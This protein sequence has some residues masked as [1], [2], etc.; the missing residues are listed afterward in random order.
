MNEVVRDCSE[1]RSCRKCDL[2]RILFLTAHVPG[3]YI[4]HRLHSPEPWHTQINNVSHVPTHAG[5][6]TYAT[7]LG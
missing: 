3:D 7:S 5:S 1:D 6:H 4:H 2:S